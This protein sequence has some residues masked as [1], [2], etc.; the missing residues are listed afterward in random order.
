MKIKSI[1][2]ATVVTAGLGA[3]GLT[4]GNAFTD[5]G[6]F[7]GI[8]G[9]GFG[10]RMSEGSGSGF[11]NE[12]MTGMMGRTGGMM[13]TGYNPE[14][15]SGNLMSE[16]EI[17]ESV[18][19]YLSAYEEELMIG[20]LFIFADSEYYVS[21]EEKN[22]GIGAFELLINP[23]TG[24]IRPEQGPNMMWNEKYGMAGS[25]MGG[26][27]GGQGWNNETSGPS[28]VTREQA[29]KLA[30]EYLSKKDSTLSAVDEGHQFYGYYTLHVNKDGK[31][32]GMLSVNAF[33][34]D[35]WYH[36]WHGELLEVTGGH[37]D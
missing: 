33:T 3:F 17:L 16:K 28:K 2:A 35:V 27:M 21:V 31:S 24:E 14:A 11:S 30:N 12:F 7:M 9:N 5:Q 4:N 6:G 22:T 32:S 1:V 10:S 20:D 8:E 29:V 34:G 26:M 15:Y 36:D 18:E 13:G 37:N 25:G 23:Y 19:K